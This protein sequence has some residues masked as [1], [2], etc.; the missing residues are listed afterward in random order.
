M[1]SSGPMNLHRQWLLGSLPGAW[2]PGENGSQLPFQFR[3]QHLAGLNVT[4][5]VAA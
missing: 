4:H 2:S 1:V 3:P 5:M